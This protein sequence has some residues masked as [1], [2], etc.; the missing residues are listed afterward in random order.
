MPYGTP[1]KEFYKV[2]NKMV[3]SGG[4]AVYH[5]ITPFISNAVVAAGMV[6]S[7]GLDQNGRVWDWG[8]NNKG[9]LGD[10]SI[11]SKLTPVSILGANKTFCAIA[12]GVYHALAMDNNKGVW[13]WG[14][15]IYGQVGNNSTTN[16]CTPVMITTI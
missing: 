10:N 16:K 2:N 15:N 3:L 6:H 14:Y 9:Q 8:Y 12:C 11:T 1:T 5:N 4:D 13:G 7:I